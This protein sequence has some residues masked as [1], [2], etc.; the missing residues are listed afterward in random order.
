M[1]ECLSRDLSSS[2][3]SSHEMDFG[4]AIVHPDRR[5]NAVV[6]Y[7]LEA[8]MIVASLLALFG[9]FMSVNIGLFSYFFLWTFLLMACCCHRF[10][11]SKLQASF[12][13]CHILHASLAPLIA[14]LL[15]VLSVNLYY[16]MD[17]GCQKHYSS[18]KAQQQKNKTLLLMNMLR[19]RVQHKDA[20][21]EQ[22]RWP[23]A[24]IVNDPMKIA[25]NP[26]CNGV[27]LKDVHTV[28]TTS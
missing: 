7:R 17:S 25:F 18:F 27:G 24:R 12:S 3:F 19:S 2:M 13:T 26:L 15:Y 11:S 8:N 9:V 21:L 1:M 4:V 20:A 23:N 28:A 22:L 6:F 10:L 5:D 14:I 16:Q